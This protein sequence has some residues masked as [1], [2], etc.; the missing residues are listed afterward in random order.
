MNRSSRSRPPPRSSR[1][2]AAG[3]AADRVPLQQ[4]LP[5]A[6]GRR[7]RAVQGPDHLGQH[8]GTGTAGQVRSGRV[9]KDRAHRTP[10]DRRPPTVH[11]DAHP[12][13]GVHHMVQ[14][15]LLLHLQA[16][17]D[18]WNTRSHR[19]LHSA[20]PTVSN[21][22]VGQ[23]IRRSCGQPTPGRAVCWGH[24]GP[25]WMVRRAAAVALAFALSSVFALVRLLP[26]N[27]ATTATG[28]TVPR[29]ARHRCIRTRNRSPAQPRPA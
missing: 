13:P 5:H 17:P 3:P 29:S 20:L 2:R 25:P 24:L 7:S 6:V 15:D 12:G 23:R 18:D 4:E 21:H 11:L 28:R 9:S 14:V 19:G 1:D 26:V 8:P 27:G 16:H 10:D 22:D